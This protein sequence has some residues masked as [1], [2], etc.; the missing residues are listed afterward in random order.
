MKG[1][2]STISRVFSYLVVFLAALLIMV[3]VAGVVFGYQKNGVSGIWGGLFLLLFSTVSLWHFLKKARGSVKSISGADPES[4]TQMEMENRQ[5]KK[6]VARM[7]K[8]GIGK[9]KIFRE[10]VNRGAKEKMAAHYIASYPD[11]RL[12]F[13]YEGKVKLLINI[14]FAQAVLSFFVGYGMGLERQM[15]SPWLPGLFVA[16]I[17]LLLMWG[18]HKQSAMAYNA[19]FLLAILQIPQSLKSI[20]VTPVAT[21]IGLVVTFGT[22]ALVLYLRSKLFPDFV[23]FTPKKVKGRY[24]FTS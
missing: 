13:R 11:E 5:I 14:M 2:P 10:L 16:I 7:M 20:G 18:F 23:G 8:K 22:L 17:P 6:E 12:G 24:E 15:Q 19:Y 21:S 4:A 3:S 1:S 9:S